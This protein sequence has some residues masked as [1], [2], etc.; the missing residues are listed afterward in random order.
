MKKYILCPF[1][2]ES[3]NEGKWF[4]CNTPYLKRLFK[5][6]ESGKSNLKVVYSNVDPNVE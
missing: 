6:A 5:R 3:V 2:G 4:E 1:P